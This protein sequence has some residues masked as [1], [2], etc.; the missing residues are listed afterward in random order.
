MSPICGGV[1]YLAGY[2]LLTGVP[3]LT[4]SRWSRS[5]VANEPAPTNDKIPTVRLEDTILV[6]LLAILP[7]SFYL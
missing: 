1:F 3:A 2:S 4:C 5:P 6:K 7:F